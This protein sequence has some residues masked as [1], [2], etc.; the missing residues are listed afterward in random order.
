MSAEDKL[1]L[2]EHDKP[3][4]EEEEQESVPWL[5]RN[6]YMTTDF[7][8]E[9][10]FGTPSGKKQSANF[11]SNILVHL[12]SFPFSFPFLCPSSSFQILPLPPLLSALLSSVRFILSSAF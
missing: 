7:G 12:I 10:L 1:L 2:K 11:G 5:K 8:K 4:R 3:D 6:E 9:Q